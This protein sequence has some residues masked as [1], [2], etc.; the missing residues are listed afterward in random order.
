[1]NFGEVRKFNTIRRLRRLVGKEVND[2][3]TI[4]NYDFR[5]FKIGTLVVDEKCD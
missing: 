4:G 1:M 3:W 5:L 2:S